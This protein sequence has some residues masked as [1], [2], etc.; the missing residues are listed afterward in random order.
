MNRTE[1]PYA[2]PENIENYKGDW[3][4]V[5]RC[6][7]YFSMVLVFIAF[8]NA[9]HLWFEIRKDGNF[10]TFSSTEQVKRMFFGPYTSGDTD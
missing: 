5:K 4:L 6:S 1:N 7:F 9:S 10:R 2:T 3:S 8:I